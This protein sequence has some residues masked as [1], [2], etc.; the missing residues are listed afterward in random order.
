MQ[1]ISLKVAQNQKQAS[2][3]ASHVN[4]ASQAIQKSQANLVSQAKMGNC[5]LKKKNMVKKTKKKYKEMSFLKK[6]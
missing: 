6:T 3:R 4:Q 1:K 2:D 5:Y